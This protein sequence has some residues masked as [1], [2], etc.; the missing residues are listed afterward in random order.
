MNNRRIAAS[1]IW[2]LLGLALGVLS[3][4]AVVD[5]Y[6]GGMGSAFVMVGIVNL[7]QQ[8]RLRRNPQYRE[9]ME[10][11][12][13]DERLKY[14]RSKAWAWAGYLFVLI[15]AAASIALRVLGQ[16]ALSTAAGL[17]VCILI[18]LFWGSYAVLL[19]KY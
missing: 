8:L 4:A 17:S 11:S 19:K 9:K 13:S 10:T 18:A 14:L 16:N 7:L 2:V 3:A 5:A 6:W 15:A 1:L 12:L